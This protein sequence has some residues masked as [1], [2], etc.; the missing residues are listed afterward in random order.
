VVGTDKSVETPSGIS[1]FVLAVP[2]HV[3]VPRTTL[4]G[5]TGLS[6][7]SVRRS[8]D[9]GSPRPPRRFHDL[10]VFRRPAVRSV[11]RP[12]G[13]SHRLR[14]PLRVWARTPSPVLHGPDR[15]SWGFT[16]LQRHQRRDRARQICLSWR[17]PSLGFLAPSTVCSPSGLADTLGP[18]PLLG[19]SLVTPFRTGRP[20]CIAAPAAS[21]RP[22]CSTASNSEEY[23]VESS[24]NLKT[25]EPACPGSTAVVPRPPSPLRSTPST[26]RRGSFHLRFS[27]RA[28]SS[29]PSGRTMT[30]RTRR[31]RVFHRPADRRISIAGHPRLPWG[32]CC[33]RK[34]LRRLPVLHFDR[35]RHARRSREFS[36]V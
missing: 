20:W 13:G 36:E 10:E 33:F 6:E 18:L 8:G 14:L 23:E 31:L 21:Y 3:A 11:L 25:L 27:P 7:R 24:A 35:H 17:R 2:R 15:P 16:P 22:R 28:L 32:S 4:A 12:T 34:T 29:E 19:F 1:D 30:F 9:I 5:L 26:S